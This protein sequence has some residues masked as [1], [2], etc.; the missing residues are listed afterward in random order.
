MKKTILS[1]SIAISC[2]YASDGLLLQEAKQNFAPLP[3]TFPSAQYTMTPEKIRLGKMLFHEKRV[4]IDGTTSCVKCHPF[5]YYGADNLEKARGNFGKL[6][7]RNAPTVL[8]AAGQITQHWRGDR[9]DVEDQAKKALLGKA[10]FGAPSYEWVEK[11]LGSI[12]QYQVLFQ[13]AFPNDKNPISV[14]NYAEAIGAWE[15]T[16]STPSRFDEFLEGRSN[17]LTQEEKAGLKTFIKTGC[18]SCHSGALLGGTMN[19]KFGMVAPYWEYTKSKKIDEGRYNVTKKEEDKYVFKV[20]QLRNVA[21][22]SPYFHDGSVTSLKEAVKIMA[23]VQL[24]VD[25]SQEETQSIYLF[26]QSLTGK[27]SQDIVTVPILPETN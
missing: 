1:I 5:S 19:Q 25:L 27:L 6:N 20:P 18:A 12:P 17:A 4:S 26:L 8:N 2:A 14:D 9:K 11:R 21:M 10:S 23:K 16:L 15:R 24:G 22:T 3:K 13:K 7:P